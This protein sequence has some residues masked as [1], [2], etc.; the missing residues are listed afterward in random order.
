MC[1]RGYFLYLSPSRF[2]VLDRS[3]MIT[4]FPTLHSVDKIRDTIIHEDVTYKIQTSLFSPVV[5]L[6]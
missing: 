5:F 3:I 2:E 6:Y 1:V 4:P